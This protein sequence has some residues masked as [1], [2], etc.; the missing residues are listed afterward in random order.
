MLDPKPSASTH[1]L[2]RVIAILAAVVCLVI[3]I[4]IW[5][6]LATYQAMFPLPALYFIEMVAL[7]LLSAYTFF[8]ADPRDRSLAWGAVGAIGAFSLM[9][10]FSVGFFYLPVALLFAIISATSDVRNK[11]HLLAHLGICL[12]AGLI[13]AGLMFAVIRL[14][15]RG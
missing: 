11:Q 8:R 15:Y 10:A 3:T 5:W 1:P 14:L 6:S 12:L 9:G 13:Q 2:E 4:V 7:S